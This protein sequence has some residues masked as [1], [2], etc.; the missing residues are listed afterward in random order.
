MQTNNAF[1]MLT[2]NEE[3]QLEF[4]EYLEYN[5]DLRK[6]KTVTGITPD[7]ETKKSSAQ[8]RSKITSAAAKKAVEHINLSHI[9]DDGQITLFQKINKYNRSLNEFES[10]GTHQRH[11]SLNDFTI[12][13]I[14]EYIT[15][16]NNDVYISANSFW[17]PKRSAETL[18][19]INSLYVDI[20]KHDVNKV[21]IKEI[22]ELL[23]YYEDYVWDKIL[24]RP[25]LIISSGR[26]IQIYWMLDHL[27]KQG[28]GLWTKV[29]QALAKSIDKNT[30]SQFKLDWSCTDI[31]R[32]LRLAGTQ[33]SKSRTQAKIVYK[34]DATYRLDVLTKDYFRQ[35][36]ISPRR[37]KELEE[38]KSLVH[39]TAK[40]K[41]EFKLHKLLTTHSLHLARLD[42]IV[43]LQEMRTSAGDNCEGLREFL[44]FLYRYYSCFAISDPEVVLENT[45]DFNSKFIE[46]L[47][48]TEVINQTISA[49]KAYDKW[50]EQYNLILKDEADGIST[51]NKNRKGYNYKT[52]TLVKKLQITDEEAR[53]LQTLITTR[54]KYDRDNASQR[55]K[56]RNKQGLT[57]K[58]Q[59]IIE[60]TTQI[61]ELKAQGMTQV[62]VA[63]ALGVNERTI[64][65]YWAK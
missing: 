36:Y 63:D 40:Q 20:D 39:K 44:C 37:R 19:H 48:E 9:D 2:E 32:V 35:L 53:K 4:M 24:P 14:Q 3:H 43:K 8:K 16:K 38:N 30:P 15:H 12:D 33:N 57:P 27:P 41:Q 28:L 42:D 59:K 7:K 34:N 29:E 6:H 47:E 50:L 17:C 13:S 58:Q 51:I 49:Q 64:R 52:E 25:S 55:K 45:L 31:T 21:S 60:R 11:Y 61:Q 5:R 22:S 62:Q 23:S 46:P 1:K 18:R 56:R 54:V 26:G 10:V 65:R